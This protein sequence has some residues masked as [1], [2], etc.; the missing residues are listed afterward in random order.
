M[1]EVVVGGKYFNSVEEAC[2]AYNLE[3]SKIKMKLNNGWSYDE[4]FG[5]V[6]KNNRSHEYL[7]VYTINGVEYSSIKEACTCIG[8]NYNT[9][10]KRLSRGWSFDEAFGIVHR[11]KRGGVGKPLVIKGI[12]FNSRLEAAEHYGVDIS[13]LYTRVNL[14][15]SVEEALGIKDRKRKGLKSITVGENTY[16]SI[17]S[18]CRDLGVDRGLVNCR[19]KNGWSIDEAFGIVERQ[20]R[21]SVVVG[22]KNYNSISE[23]CR[24]LGVHY[25]TV[26]HRV[27]KGWSIDEAFGLVDRKK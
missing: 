27:R 17:A 20:K 23:A 10:I 7:D 2:K 3:C 4:A 22:G 9:V 14:G 26:R 1:R 5:L 16:E 12:R 15:W 25:Q 13:S 19:L 21:Y 18:A 11:N 24:D 8:I 6:E